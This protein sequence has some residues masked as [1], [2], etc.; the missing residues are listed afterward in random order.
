VFEINDNAPVRLDNVGLVPTNVNMACQLSW[1][2]YGTPFG[3]DDHPN[4]AGYSL[5]ASAIQAALPTK[6]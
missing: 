3:P 5:I 2:C 1:F 6:W 4:D